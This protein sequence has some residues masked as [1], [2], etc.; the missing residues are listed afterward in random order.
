MSQMLIGIKSRIEPFRA[1]LLS[2][3]SNSPP[4]TN[5]CALCGPNGV[6][7]TQSILS[8]TPGWGFHPEFYHGDGLT[9]FLDM[10]RLRTIDG[11]RRLAVIDDAH[12]LSNK[13]WKVVE[14]EA[15]S[16]QIPIVL[17]VEDQSQIPWTVRR[18][19]LRTELSRPSPS[20]LRKFLT[21]IRDDRDLTH[22]DS[23]IRDMAEQIQSFRQAEL[24]ILTTPRGTRLRLDSVED[25][26]GASPVAKLASVE[27]NNADPEI[28]G[29][30][31]VLHSHGWEIPGM[32][33]LV[34]DYLS[35]IQTQSQDRVPYRNR[36]LRG[37]TRRI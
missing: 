20:A 37:S 28:V 35:T 4:D 5:P 19:T 31:I 33:S 22:T 29:T 17:T 6:G 30:G 32:S 9:S 3:G 12:L 10:V 11:R 34:E 2:W 23:E 13:E 18:G 26:T 7:K 21:Q 24:A 16:K 25:I 15:K 27:F 1:W 8:L 14:S 36:P